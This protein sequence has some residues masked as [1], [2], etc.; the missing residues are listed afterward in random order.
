MKSVSYLGLALCLLLVLPAQ[1]EVYKWTDEYGQVHYGDKPPSEDTPEF[2]LRSPATQDGNAQYEA[3][4]DAQRRA[5]Q[6]KLS[7][8][9]EA[10]RRDKE[11]AV[12][13]RKEKQAKRA[14]NCKLAQKDLIILL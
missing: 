10:D 5:N 1:A 14:H 9:L 12:T 3:P 4:T 6:K 8:S 11:Q 2:K 7:D 13:K